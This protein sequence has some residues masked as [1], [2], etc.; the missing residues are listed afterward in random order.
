MG[1]LPERRAVASVIAKSGIAGD[2][3]SLVQTGLIDSLAN[4]P[5]RIEPPPATPAVVEKVPD[6]LLDQIV[7]ALIVSADEFPLDLPC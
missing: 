1:E 6:G 7:R 5:E 3:H 2:Q 4:S